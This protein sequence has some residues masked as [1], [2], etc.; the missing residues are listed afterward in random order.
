MPK[1]KKKMGDKLFSE[2]SDKT[3]LKDSL[4]EIS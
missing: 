4:R 2:E 3:Y 1:S